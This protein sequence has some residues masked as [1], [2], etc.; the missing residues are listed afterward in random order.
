M[1]PGAITM[2]LILAPL[3]PFFVFLAFF[4]RSGVLIPPE[5]YD[6]ERDSRSFERCTRAKLF[7]IRSALLRDFVG[8]I[9][10]FRVPGGWLFRLWAS[11]T[12]AD[13]NGLRF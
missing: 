7:S 1:R 11:L 12:R 6:K 9:K 13:F 4:L 5:I 2:F 10:F 3:L 8:L